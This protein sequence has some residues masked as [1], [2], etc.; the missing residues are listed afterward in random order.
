DVAVVV[1]TD[2][3]ARLSAE[4]RSRWAIRQVPLHVLVDGTDLRDGIDPVPHDIHN[5]PNVTTAGATPLELSEAYRSALADSDGD[6]DVDEHI[7]AALSGT[8]GS[9]VQ[10]ARKSGPAERVVNPRSAA[11]GDGFVA[12]AAARA[13]ADA[14]ALD[15]VEPAARAAVSR[16]HAFIVVHRRDN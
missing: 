2:S 6:G 5:R 10:A 15:A 8:S 14:A 7:S 1:V 11:R 12:F 4:V 9:A 3:S 13:A 16:S